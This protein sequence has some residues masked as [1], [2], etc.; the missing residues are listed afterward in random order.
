MNERKPSTDPLIAFYV[1]VF[2]VYI[3]QTMH[4]DGVFK[5][6]KLNFR[7]CADADAVKFN[8]MYNQHV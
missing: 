3:S 8:L 4:Y 6:V 5:S 1:W 7:F 2:S